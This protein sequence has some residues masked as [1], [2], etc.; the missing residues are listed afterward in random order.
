MVIDHLLS[1]FSEPKVAYVYC[2]YRDKTN[3]SLHNILGSI[4][5]QLLMITTNMPDAVV[6]MLESLQKRG[7]KVELHIVSHI[8]KLA[9][10]QL[11]VAGPFLVIDALDELEPRVRLELLKALQSE[12]GGT[13]IFLTSR[14]HIASDVSRI[15]RLHQGDAIQITPNSIDIRAYL[16]H[17]ID[18][19]WE[20]NP[21]DMN[22]QLKEEI[23]DA[24]LSKA[25]GM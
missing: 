14:P 20:M 7:N 13:H 16:G 23:L 22:E 24:I 1:H 4:L 21:E 17:E 5:K 19:D 8:L 6:G 3:Q 18:L 15:L 25:Q 10:P 12:F 9:I 2:D 11:N